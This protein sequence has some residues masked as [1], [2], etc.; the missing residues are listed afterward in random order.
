MDIIL[1]QHL[2]L[3]LVFHAKLMHFHVLIQ[4]TQQAVFLGIIY[5]VFCVFLKIKD[6]MV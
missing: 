5:K 6:P 3:K 4:P 1:I 2:L